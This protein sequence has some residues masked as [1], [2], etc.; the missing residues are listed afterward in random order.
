MLTGGCFCGAV[1]YQADGTPFDQT[2]CH[3]VNCRRSSGAPLV[4]WFSVLRS[5]FRLVAGQP[6]AFKSSEHGTRRFCNRCGTQLTFE[7][8]HSADQIDVTIC[9]LDDPNGVAPRD[10]TFVAS[11]IEWLALTDG[12]PHYQRARRD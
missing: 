5:Q 9:S 4:A 11:R 6:S 10:H 2:S 1:R 8:T 3:C 7:S 12:L